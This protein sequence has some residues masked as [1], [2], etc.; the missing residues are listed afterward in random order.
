MAIVG[1]FTDS[2]L[3]KWFETL[4]WNLGY[5]SF[6]SLEGATTNKITVYSQVSSIYSMHGKLALSEAK[7]S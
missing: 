2:S 3:A 1:E 7:F 5:S 4:A 6:F